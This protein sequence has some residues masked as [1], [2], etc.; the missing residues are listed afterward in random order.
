MAT[1]KKTLEILVKWIGK[2]TNKATSRAEAEEMNQDRYLSLD[3]APQYGGYT[4][5]EIN[6]NSGAHHNPLE[7]AGMV[8]RKKA[9][10]MEIYLRG[11]LLGLEYSREFLNTNKSK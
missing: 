4:L 5:V 8:D 7:K 1:S 6:I 9:G 2:E 10:E 11:I 3:H